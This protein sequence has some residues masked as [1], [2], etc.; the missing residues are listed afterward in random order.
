M[1]I[2]RYLLKNPKFGD[3]FGEGY[4]E[5]SLQH[6]WHFGQDRGKDK[7]G[8]SRCKKYIGVGCLESGLMESDIKL[9]ITPD[10]EHPRI[11]RVDIETGKNGSHISDATDNAKLVNKLIKLLISQNNLHLYR[12]S[13][14]LDGK[15]PDVYTFS[16]KMPSREFYF[17]ENNPP[18]LIVE[19]NKKDLENL[20]IARAHFPGHI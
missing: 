9:L 17:H 5:N 14:H 3:I 20:G 13:A 16:P 2:Y 8:I 12:C 1:K 11:E 6:R 7:I 19:I 10:S 18:P 4:V 15:Y